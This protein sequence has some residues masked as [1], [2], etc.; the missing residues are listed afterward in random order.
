MGYII[1]F[2]LKKGFNFCHYFLIPLYLFFLTKINQIYKNAMT[3]YSE[4][5]VATGSFII[6]TLNMK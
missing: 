2:S 5:Q 1:Y 6:Y 4:R 3:T